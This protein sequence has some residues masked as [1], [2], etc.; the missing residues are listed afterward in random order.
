MSFKHPT[1]DFLAQM[2]S[3][4]EI[5]NGIVKY[6]VTDAA[7]AN[8]SERTKEA[9]TTKATLRT[10]ILTTIDYLHKNDVD[11][12]ENVAL[13]A[14]FLAKKEKNEKYTAAPVV[15]VDDILKLAGLLP[16]EEPKKNDNAASKNNAK[17]LV[18][19]GGDEFYKYD[20]KYFFDIGNH[21]SASFGAGQDWTKNSYWSAFSEFLE[22]LK[23]KFKGIIIDPGSQSWVRGFNLRNF[24]T[25]IRPY[26]LPNA[27][28]ISSKQLD[29]ASFLSEQWYNYLVRHGFPA[30]AQFRLAD[31]TNYMIYFIHGNFDAKD[32]KIDNL[33]DV[34]K[35]L[36]V[37]NANRY[38]DW[39]KTTPAIVLR[40]L[41]D[42]FEHLAQSYDV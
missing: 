41:T 25:A 27:F 16:A 37:F 13:L 31:P 39:N 36:G 23:P 38:V 34:N 12:D 35:I 4:L 2:L 14:D 40:E 24:F 10:L 22:T 30:I 3:P 26:L 15:S 7:W 6:Q 19:G 11:N 9:L 18:I 8:G 29:G 33:H 20:R 5:K 32:I 17:I 42:V 28:A 1:K 21:P